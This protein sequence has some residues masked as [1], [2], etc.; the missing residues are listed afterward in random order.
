MA[1]FNYHATC[2]LVSATRHCGKTNQMRKPNITE[3][4]RHAAC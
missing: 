1:Q 2:L 3:F 4:N